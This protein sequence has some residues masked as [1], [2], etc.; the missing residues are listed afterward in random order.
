MLDQ[1]VS[2]AAQAAIC[3]VH[4]LG[5]CGLTAYLVVS[6][7]RRSVVRLGA[8]PALGYLAHRLLLEL[9]RVSNSIIFGSVYIGNT[10]IVL[11]QCINFLIVRCYDGQ[12]LVG[13][14]IYTA[15][16]PIS[17]RTWR[18]LVL[19]LNLRG[20]DTVWQDRNMH[21]F[22]EYCLT[23]TTTTT[24]ADAGK[25]GKT[26]QKPTVHRGR[27]VTRQ[28]VVFA[29]QYLFADLAY[30]MGAVADPEM[31]EKMFGAGSEF[32]YASATPEQWVAKLV[33]GVFGGF[34]PGRSAIDMWYRALAIMFVASGANEP[35]YWPP[36]FGSVGE[37]YTLRR[38]WR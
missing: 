11:L 29:W 5:V 22:P 16:D 20:R 32:A 38:V 26:T 14:G 28:L 35:E 23:T 13:A 2:M 34:G 12:D 15:A 18:A 21:E 37:A 19:L 9:A 6:T 7:P 27:F 17:V 30:S 31:D 1:A 4:F 10:M 3:L 33:V 24:A 36:L 8:L 25:A